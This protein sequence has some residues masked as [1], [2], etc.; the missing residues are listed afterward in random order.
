MVVLNEQDRVL[1]SLHFLQD[2]PGK[3]AVHLLIVLPIAGPEERTRV[4]DVAQRPETF[5]GEA[6]V[7]AFF[8]FLA[9]PYTP[10]RVLWLIRGNGEAIM[11]VHSFAISVPASV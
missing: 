7:I 2:G 6:V 1:R 10:Q 3:L 8:F 11:L 4:R 9:E 5:V